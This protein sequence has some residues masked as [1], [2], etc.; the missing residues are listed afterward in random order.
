MKQLRNKITDQR[1]L[2]LMKKFL[3]TKT[4]DREQDKTQERTIGIPQGGILSPTLC[5][6]VMDRFDKYMEGQTAKFH[7]GERRA[8]N[9]EYQRLE[10][11]RRKAKNK[12]ERRQLLLQMRRIGNVNK[13][14][15][16][17]RR[18]KYIRYADDFV[19]LMVGSIHEARMMKNNSKELLK[20]NCGVELNVEKTKITNMLKGF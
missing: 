10:Y 13:F 1:V 3:E 4:L 17:Y 6:I 15:S 2:Q 11:K 20:N 9:R 16:K 7:K 5:N 19:I 18:M 12:K 14:D 8:H